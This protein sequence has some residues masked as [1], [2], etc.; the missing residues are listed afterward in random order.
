[1]RPLSNPIVKQAAAQIQAAMKSGKEED[2]RQAWEEFGGAVADSIKQDFELAG[3]DKRILMERGYRVLTTKEQA[4]FEKLIENAKS[5]SPV[6]S[7]T[8]LMD[9]GGMPETIIEDV[10]KNLVNEHP[11]L[12][13][14]S[15]TNVSYLTKWLM[16][17][18]TINTAV[19]GPINS[20]I[21][22]EITSSFKILE[23]TQCKVSCFAVI[24]KDM[25]DL[26]PTFLDAYIR[27]ILTDAL[28][29]ALEKAIVS[30]S[31]K[32]MP[33]GLT[34][35]I[36]SSA[37]VVDGEYPEKEKVK[38][39]SFAPVQYGALIA[40]MC[41]TEKGVYREISD[42]TLICN[43]V[44]YYKKVMPA[45][46]VVNLNGT[47]TGNVFPVPTT[48]CQSAELEEGT[49]LLVLPK[50]YFIGLGSSKDGTITY[51]DSVQFLEDNRVYLIKMFANGRAFDNTVALLLDISELD[52]AY[53]TVLNKQDTVVA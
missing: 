21:T 30:G 53:I 25:L 16:N 9:I 20:E 41:K 35:N 1:M 43:P 17:D 8:S 31:G 40:Q 19:W 38:V 27:T 6:Q 24:P 14:V 29:C 34:R 11:L 15:F 2:I 3:G 46:T 44:D 48:V 18:H 37:A 33:I 26:G 13:A 22:K 47:Y 10:Y 5:P 49:A 4:F 51:D 12:D 36:S 39:T 7:F 45:T 32:N 52:P 42:L 28:A 23:M 50:E